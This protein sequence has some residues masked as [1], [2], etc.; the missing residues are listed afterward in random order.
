MAFA[1]ASRS[2]AAGAL[3]VL[4]A[5]EGALGLEAFLLHPAEM[6]SRSSATE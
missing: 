1:M 4:V 5:P 3:G 6:K 2:L